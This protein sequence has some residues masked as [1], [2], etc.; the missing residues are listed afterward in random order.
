MQP[1]VKLPTST[2]GLQARLP[3]LLGSLAARAHEPALD[4]EDSH[5]RACGGSAATRRVPG[6]RG[7]LGS[8]RRLCGA[9]SV[10]SGGWIFGHYACR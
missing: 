6:Q 1:R 8:V 7:R 9:P 5:W 3:T 2:S 4:I 10:L